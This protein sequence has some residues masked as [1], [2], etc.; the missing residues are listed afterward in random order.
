[1]AEI[2]AE[3]IHSCEIPVLGVL[4]NHDYG[5]YHNWGSQEAQAANLE[6][7]KQQHARM[8]YKLLLDEHISLEKDGEKLVLLG[9]ENWGRGFIEKGDLDKALAGVAKNA[10]KI[11]LSHDPSH[12]QEIVKSH[13]TPVQLTL[14]GHTHGMQFGVETPL[15]K[16]SP[17]Q[18]R[19]QHWAGVARENNRQLYVNRGF[20]FIGFSGRVGIWP[21]IAVLE[22]R[23]RQV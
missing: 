7:L 1:E 20:G 12:W 15:F 8:G 5:M 3:D 9:V 6:Q 22:L 10:F 19:Y 17:V 21:E 18:Y 16:W 13:P 2:L 23:R 4:G 11:L 14:S